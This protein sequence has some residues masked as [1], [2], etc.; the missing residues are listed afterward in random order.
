MTKYAEKIKLNKARISNQ[1]LFAIASRCILF[2][3]LT[4][5]NMV[6]VNVAMTKNRGLE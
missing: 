2:L 6:Y 4:T 1:A 5:S 3:A